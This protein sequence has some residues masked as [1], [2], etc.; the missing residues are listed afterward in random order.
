MREIEEVIKD[1]IVGEF[2]VNK[3]EMAL[4]NDLSLIHQE[5]IDSLGIFLFIGFLEEQFG[6][7][8]QEEDVVLEHFETINAIKGLVMAKLSPKLSA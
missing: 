4:E 6:I 5:I 8:I 2:M 3:P 1:Y 7:T